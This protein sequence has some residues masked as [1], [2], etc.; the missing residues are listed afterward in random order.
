VSRRFGRQFERGR[1][2]N[3]WQRKATALSQDSNRCAGGAFGD[4]TRRR[5]AA[6]HE[7]YSTNT[8]ESR[9]SAPQSLG[10]RDQFT[11]RAIPRPGV[12]SA[13]CRPNSRRVARYARRRERYG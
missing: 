1:T 9:L 10:G 12:A 5:G 3:E 4:V 11:D 2:W 13:F 7:L 8:A 6:D